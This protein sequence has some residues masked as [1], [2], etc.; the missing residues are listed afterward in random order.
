MAFTAQYQQPMGFNQHEMNYPSFCDAEQSYLPTTTCDESNFIG[1]PTQGF[2]QNMNE[3]YPFNPE[4]L[5][6]LSKYDMAHQQYQMESDYSFDH[7]PPVLSSTSDSG[8]S[9]QSGMS[10]HMNS[11]S[12]QPQQMNDWNQQFNVCPSIFQPD[13]MIPTSMFESGTI[14]GEAKIG[15]VEAWTDVQADTANATTRD[16]SQNQ[17]V[18]SSIETS[19]GAYGDVPTGLDNNFVFTS[20]SS[21]SPPRAPSLPFTPRSPV[22]ERVKGRRQ[23]STVSSPKRLFGTIRLARSGSVHGGVTERFTGAQYPEVPA[24]HSPQVMAYPLMPSPAPSTTSVRSPRSSLGKVHTS[25]HLHANSYQPYPAY[26]G[27]RRPSVSSIHSR[28]SQGSSSDESNKGLCPYPTC[29][30]HFKDLKAHMLT[31]Q[32]ERPEKC[33][34]PTC[35][36]HTKGFARKYDKNRHTLTHYK[37]TMVCGFCPGSGSS[38]EKS[39]NRADVFKRHL[40]SVHGV[41]QTP[42][43]ARRKSP[44]GGKRASYSNVRDV[45]GMCS[46][47]GIMFA[48]AQEFYEHLDDCVLRVVQQAEPSEAINERLLMSVA[49]DPAVHASMKKH[50][51]PTTIDLGAP[52]SYEEEDEEEDAAAEDDDDANDGTYGARSGRSGKGASRSRKSA[53]GNSSDGAI[54]KP[55]SAVSRKQ[56]LTHSKN[57]VSLSGPPALVKGSKRKRN[58]PLS[59]GAAPENM[60]MKKRVLCVFDGPRRLWK[61]DMMLDNAHE[62][63]IPTSADGRSYT[64]ELDVLTMQRA[65]A[66]LNATE[67]EKGPWLDEDG[68]EVV[69]EK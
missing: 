45:A 17:P 37:G 36:Y 69:T 2:A 18:F 27:S 20:P 33:P 23:A 47:C 48:N 38:A 1:Y 59:W 57:G 34:I 26:P 39:F 28:H 9:I 67:E 66:V 52:A 29:G 51:L 60:H 62:V 22:L 14:S 65:E 68:V 11:P 40:T 4:Q 54:G 53:A 61:D 21:S 31:H 25:P 63:R 12:T 3:P 64:T 30:R 8:A 24:L 56:G 32:N 44:A 58:Y 6:Q 5:E 15:C 42:P 19:D 13:N 50:N 46:T 55:S 16:P 49:D 7:Q 43:N 35:E 41:E 10:S